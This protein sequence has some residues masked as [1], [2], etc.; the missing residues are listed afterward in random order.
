MWYSAR[1]PRPTSSRNKSN[2]VEDEVVDALVTGAR[3][4][5]LRRLFV[6]GASSWLRQAGHRPDKAGPWLTGILARR[7]VKVAAVAQ[8]AKTARIAWAVLTSG[9]DYRA[10]T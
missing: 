9:E 4:L 2:H 1:H 7:P 3:E 8:A 10:A 5:G 6:L